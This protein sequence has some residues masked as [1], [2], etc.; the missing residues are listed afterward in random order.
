MSRVRPDLD[1]PLEISPATARKN[2]LFALA[3][4]ALALVIF[5]ATIA[6]AFI[7]LAVAD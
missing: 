2:T 1:D 4:V 5:A 6:I 3:L 7:Y